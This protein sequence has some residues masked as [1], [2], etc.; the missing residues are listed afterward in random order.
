MNISRTGLLAGLGLLVLLAVLAVPALTAE[1]P[2]AVAE[3]DGSG[4]KA[5][6]FAFEDINPKSPTFGKK[7]RLSDVY[8]ERG[9]LLNFVASWC[10]PC[11]DE[12]PILESLHE[13]DAATILVVAADENGAGPENVKIV[14]DRAGATMPVLF[15]PTEEAERIF[16]FYTYQVIPATY[17]IDREGELKNWHTGMRSRAK[18]ER[19]IEAYLGS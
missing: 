2:A 13:D 11:R 14:I 7:I 1:R 5:L 6:D 12:L 19:E 15:A 9:V 3:A 18:L 17:F 8:G 4:T 10:G 16:E